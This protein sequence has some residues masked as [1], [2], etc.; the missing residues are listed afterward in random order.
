M[1][2]IYNEKYIE[3]ITRLRVARVERSVT[4][5]QLAEILDVP[6][7]FVSKVECCERRLDIGEFIYWLNALNLTPN[8]VL[9]MHIKQGGEE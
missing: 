4:Q 6:Q 2:S 5:Q 7:S 8:E 3:I 9:A 1:K